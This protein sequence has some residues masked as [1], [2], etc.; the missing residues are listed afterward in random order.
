M[1]F[2]RFRRI[3]ILLLILALLPIVF[4]SA[5]SVH[6]KLLVGGIHAVIANMPED[7]ENIEKLEELA[8]NLEIYSTIGLVSALTGV[9]LCISILAGMQRGRLGAY[10]SY[11][12]K[13]ASLGSDRAKFSL[14]NLSFPNEDDLGN[15]GATLNAILA[16]LQEFEALRQEELL[17]ADSVTRA[18]INSC[19]D[20]IAV[21]DDRFVLLFFSHAFA[22]RM[23]RKITAGMHTNEIFKDMTSLEQFAWALNREGEAKLEPRRGADALIPSSIHTL[24]RSGLESRRLIVRFAP[25]TGS[26]KECESS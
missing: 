23:S 2:S 18:A 19:P 14:S 12:R 21:F 24:S 4:G 7:S 1:K 26:Y 10:R 15:L 16:Q 8:E 22:E 3:R 13:L 9:L 25:P 17:L 5:I 20:P 6:S 11:L